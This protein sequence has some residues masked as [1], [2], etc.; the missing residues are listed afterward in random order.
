[1]RRNRS[2]ASQLEQHFYIAEISL[3]AG[4][5]RTD[6]TS[7]EDVTVVDIEIDKFVQIITE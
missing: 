6:N 1:M 2:S 3:I 5:N 7:T 4:E